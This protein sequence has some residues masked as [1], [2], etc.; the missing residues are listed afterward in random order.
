MKTYI[1]SRK[2]IFG[3]QI[4]IIWREIQN[5][6]LCHTPSSSSLWREIQNSK[7][8]PSK[9]IPYVAHKI[10]MS[11]C[12]REQTNDKCKDCFGD[13]FKKDLKDKAVCMYNV[14]KYCIIFLTFIFIASILSLN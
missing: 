9:R 7:L 2:N 1:G 12:F 14:H 8:S 3:N 13:S 4:K 10:Q 11:P 6:Y 5:N